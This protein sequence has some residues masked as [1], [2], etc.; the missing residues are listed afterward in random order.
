MNKT[1]NINLGGLFFHID[2]KAYLKLR[3]YLDAISESLNDDPQGKEEIIM[4]IE[5]RI[6]ELLAEKIADEREVINEKHIDEVIVIMGQPEEYAYDDELFSENA[7]NQST[8][9]KLYRD[10]KD[11]ILGGVSSGLGHYFGID[12]A[13]VRILW[14][15]ITLFF[16]AG[17]LAYA[18]LWIIL[19]EANTTAEDLEMRGQPVN[20]D[21]IERTIK[22]EYNKIENKVRNADYSQVKTGLQDLIDTLGKILVGFFKVFGKVIGVLILIIAATTLIGMFIGLLSW[23]SIEA[24]GYG[25]QLVHVP[26]FFEHSILPKWILTL[27]FFLAIIIPFV[28]LFVLGINI[29]SKE[30]KSMGITGNLS[31]LGV[32]L[33][34]LIGMG[35]AG[36][37]HNTQ[38]ATSSSISENYEFDIA[39]KDTLQIT[40]KGNDKIANR[41]SLYRSRNLEAVQDSLGVDKLYSSYVHIDIRKSSSEKIMVKVIKTTRAFNKHKAQENAKM[42]T[43]HFTEESN[44]LNLDTY[45]LTDTDLEYNRPKID[46]IIYVPENRYVYLD[47]TTKSFIYDIKNK[48]NIYDA[49][50]A[51][52]YFLMSSDGFD[53]TDCS[54]NNY[55]EEE[56]DVNLNINK[57]GIKLSLKDGKESV[58]V[59]IDEGGIE[60]R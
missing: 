44:T 19:P 45:F 41:K 55:K 58:K 8:S 35:F 11:K 25:E 37:E 21:S 52:H 47:N 29:L 4:D 50:M 22:E 2:E 31:L 49:D 42:I 27:F 14:I 10:G 6:S 20:I 56:D 1:I 9:K 53:C 57:D 51:N 34:S 26:P 16:G 36:I 7:N 28:F 24:L 32:W 15:I 13:W 18:I 39:K 23:G 46:V 60:I 3:H 12:T 38:I 59:K 40:M 48:Q 54:S 17:I 5:Q 33:V 43:Y 30:K